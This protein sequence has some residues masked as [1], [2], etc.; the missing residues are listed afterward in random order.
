MS[1]YLASRYVELSRPTAT[2]NDLP[3]APFMAGAEPFHFEAGGENACLMVHGFMGSAHEV[4]GLGSYLA[5]RGITTRG[6]LLTGH[7]TRPEDMARCTYRDWVADVESALDELVASGKRVF[8]CGLS[9]GGTLTLNVAARR[10]SESRLSGVISLAAPLCLTD[11]RLGVVTVVGLI[12]RS[13]AWGQPDIKDRS[14]CERHVAYQRAGVRAMLQLLRLTRETRR[15]APRVKQPLLVVHSRHDNTVP[16]FNAELIMRT[17]SSQ[18]REL[19][20]LKNCYHVVTVD[21]ESARVRQAVAQFIEQRSSSEGPPSP[22][23]SPRRR[24]SSAIC[25][26]DRS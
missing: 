22:R 13:R 24:G 10:N 26:P 8:L 20:W 2:V 17:V 6:L 14:Q 21:Y 1:P 15:L 11:W 7:G 23:P 16:P 25:E 18:D 3:Q 9:M 12:A 5:E 19:V 4:R